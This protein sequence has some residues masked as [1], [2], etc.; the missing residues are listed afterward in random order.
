M[1]EGGKFLDPHSVN[2]YTSG[3][4]KANAAAR[5]HIS[6]LSRIRNGARGLAG[7]ATVVGVGSYVRKN[8][9]EEKEAQ[10]VIS[11]MRDLNSVEEGSVKALRNDARTR[12]VLINGG[13]N[14]FLTE[15]ESAAKMNFPSALLP[16]AAEVGQQFADF[17]RDKA[18]EG[19][20][21]TVNTAE[22]FGM[23][24]N[25]K[26]EK[27]SPKA[28][29]EEHL[30]NGMSEEDA[31]LDIARRLKAATG[32]YKRIANMMP[33]K[34]SEL[35]EALKMS[36]PT[37]ETLEIPLKDTVATLNML[38][39]GGLTGSHAGTLYRGMLTRAGNPTFVAMA[40]ARTAGYDVRKNMHLDASF[41]NPD[42]FV[43][44]LS[45]YY[46]PK[47]N[48]DPK[49]KALLKKRMVDFKNDPNSYASDE[50]GNYQAY[51]DLQKSVVND[52]VKAYGKNNKGLDAVNSELVSKRVAKALNLSNK[53]FSLLDLIED[54][55]KQGAFTPGMIKAL[56]GTEAG[57]A[58]GQIGLQDIQKARQVG[59]ETTRG[60]K[61]QLANEWD[62]AMK[63]RAESVYGT[64]EG[65][66][67]RIKAMFD[68][69]FESVEKPLDD[70]GKKINSLG[71]SMLQAD[72]GKTR[73][74]VAAGSGVAMLGGAGAVSMFGGGSVATLAAGSLATGGVGLLGV[75]GGYM[76]YRGM[77]DDDSVVDGSVEDARR[78]REFG[79]RLGRGQSYFDPSKESLKLTR[80]KPTEWP[81]DGAEPFK[82]GDSG[83]A[84]TG[85]AKRVEVTGTVTGNSEVHVMIQGELRPTAHFEALI[86]KAE[87]IAN[88]SL[89][90]HL[91]TSMQ[92]PGDNNTK[93]NGNSALGTVK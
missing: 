79:M 52:I 14:A 4:H 78:R 50:H 64:W 85:A 86:H 39:T 89:N 30:A 91:G 69:M 43:D 3:L 26:G 8:L 32:M 87:A 25:R 92:G 61:Y 46:G 84:T 80:W 10:D 20:E 15:G 74:A 18:G 37:A 12:G 70:T 83:G 40:A 57:T 17:L 68:K 51:N 31:K 71:D 35:F 2:A 90:G 27:T 88:M 11:R 6:L 63:A 41:F 36:V 48:S 77:T 53:G 81:V 29:Y 5:E 28:L 58:M 45:Q 33:G 72:Q 66:G 38:A 23:L 42:A 44:G 47:I 34:E 93:A 65:L 49:L 55:R 13:M 82:Y 56:V 73:A 21:K 62:A 1:F 22:Y 59:E 19:I 75:A 9:P 7:A 67:N 76:L 16:I 54:I 60:D 24:K